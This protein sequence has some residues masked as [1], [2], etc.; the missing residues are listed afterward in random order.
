MGK[1]G[2]ATCV[3]SAAPS[4]VAMAVPCA[5]Y[6]DARCLSAMIYSAHK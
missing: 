2:G 5:L 3:G 4:C 1:V 6:G